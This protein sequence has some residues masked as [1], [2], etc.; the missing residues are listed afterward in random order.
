[1]TPGEF[2]D[3]VTAFQTL[4]QD[5]AG[6]QGPQQAAVGNL[7]ALAL[8]C[9]NATAAHDEARELV[10]ENALRFPRLRE[11][12]QL[13]LTHAL[14]ISDRVSSDLSYFLADF[15]GADGQLQMEAR[16]FLN[17]AHEGTEG[18]MSCDFRR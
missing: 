7:F 9:A 3:A 1:M 18:I 11:E 16:R 4:L 17:A 10:E 5:P 12:A 6:L 14:E 15:Y 8:V 2:P 13:M